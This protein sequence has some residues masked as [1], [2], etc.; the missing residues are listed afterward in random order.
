[1]LYTTSAYK[2]TI[3]NEAPNIIKNVIKQDVAPCDY[4]N[5]FIEDFMNWNLDKSITNKIS[6]WCDNTTNLNKLFNNLID[7]TLINAIYINFDIKFDFL[8]IILET[9]NAII[10]DLGTIGT[11]TFEIIINDINRSKEIDLKELVPLKEVDEMIKIHGSNKERFKDILSR[12][13]YEAIIL[14]IDSTHSDQYAHVLRN[15]IKEINENKDFKNSV[16]SKINKAISFDGTKV[17]L[18]GKDMSLAFA[19]NKEEVT[20]HFYGFEYHRPSVVVHNRPLWV[21]IIIGVSFIILSLIVF[22]IIRKTKINKL[23]SRI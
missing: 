6:K 14:E 5:I 2:T 9:A 17:T 23:L 12:K 15:K 19:V 21:P 7:E 18:T 3:N 1:M 16:I 8:V 20:A 13:I 10:D 4:K 22:L 11:K